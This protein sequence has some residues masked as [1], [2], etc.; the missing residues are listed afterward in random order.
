MLLLLL[1]VLLMLLLLL[2][3]A[4][5]MIR[6]T[7]HPP[8]TRRCAAHTLHCIHRTL[9]TPRHQHY[10]PLTATTAHR[11]CSLPPPRAPH[12]A[13]TTHPISCAQDDAPRTR[14]T[15]PATPHTLLTLHCTRH[16]VHANTLLT[17]H[18]AR[19][20]MHGNTLLTLHYARHTGYPL[21]AVHS[22]RLTMRTHIPRA[23]PA[24]LCTAFN[25]PC[26]P[27]HHTR[28]THHTVRY[29]RYTVHT[30]EP[31]TAPT[32]RHT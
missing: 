13:P 28:C 21:H 16:T 4:T 7:H 15:A 23:A 5:H 29:T 31:Y 26:T 30:Y 19:H 10:T 9:H 6:C 14:Y 1:S 8:H 20:T 32:T 22:T 12:T 3:P 11:L 25:T 24:M 17:L 2:P 18:C 27:T